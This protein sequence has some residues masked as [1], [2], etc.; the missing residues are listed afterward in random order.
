MATTNFRALTPFST[1]RDT[2][3]VVNNILA[4]KLNATGTFTV[5][6]SATSTV[7]A[8]YRAGK[9]SVILLMPTTSYAAAEIATTYV[10][11]RAKNSFT[12]THA[13]NTTSR[14]FD[15]VIIG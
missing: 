7:V 6:N 11:T 13:S 9:E 5:T 15:Y 3:N 4:G 12:V 8:D 2:S 1:M 10:S 14:I